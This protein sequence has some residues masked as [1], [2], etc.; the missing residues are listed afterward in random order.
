MI[1]PNYIAAPERRC[2]VWP[3]PYLRNAHD[4]QDL[5][6]DIVRSHLGHGGTARAHRLACWV[7]PGSVPE[8]CA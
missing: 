8:F 4:A 7:D 1:W 3:L 5:T 2:T 6:Q